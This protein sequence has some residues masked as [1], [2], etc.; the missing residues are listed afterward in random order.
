MTEITYVLDASVFMIGHIS[1]GSEVRSVTVPGVV[2]ELKD[3]QSRLV[4]EQAVQEKLTVEEPTDA[5]RLKVISAAKNTGDMER[6]SDT[7]VDLLAKALELGERC[8]LITDDYAMQNVACGL[9]ITVQDI[10]QNGITHILRWRLRCDGCKRYF[11]EDEC[12]AGDMCP[13]C[14]SLVRRI[15]DR[16]K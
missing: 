13:V 9:S 14:G 12:K 8:R 1:M 15:A 10:A 6:L 2:D 7:D 11:D 3:A 5:S 4:F 16:K